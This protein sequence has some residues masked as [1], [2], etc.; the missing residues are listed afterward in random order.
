MDHIEPYR[1]I[2]Q[3]QSE[4]V[5]ISRRNREL[6][7]RCE[8]LERALSIGASVET[9]LGEAR[10]E[11]GVPILGESWRSRVRRGVSKGVSIVRPFRWL[12][13]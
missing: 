7:E 2:V 3:L 1:Q 4:I 8:E 6:R 11:L 9:S 5:K 13:V 12:G 10:H